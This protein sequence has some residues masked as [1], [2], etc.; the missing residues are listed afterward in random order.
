[1][2][3]QALRDNRNAGIDAAA[4]QL[5]RAPMGHLDNAGFQQFAKR[6]SEFEV[7]SSALDRLERELRGTADMKVTK[8][9]RTYGPGAPYIYYRDVATLAIGSLSP[10]FGG[11]EARQIRYATEVRRE[12]SRGTPEGLRA[13][14]IVREQS[15][16]HDPE[17]HRRV[18]VLAYYRG[19]CRHYRQLVSRCVR[20]AGLRPGRHCDLPD[21]VPC[22]RRSVRTG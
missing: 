9:A 20:N 4:E 7:T 21:T 6:V 17:E 3:T 19:S 22:I 15:R 2:L 8:E 12:M 18:A 16:V 14:R 1:M 5:Y 10:D 13:G 11:A